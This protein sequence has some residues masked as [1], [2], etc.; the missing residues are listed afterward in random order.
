MALDLNDKDKEELK[1]MIR[2]AINESAPKIPAKTPAERRAE[3]MSIKNP[4]QRQK[5]ISENQ[6][7]FRG[8]IHNGL[9]N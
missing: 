8:Y 4:L 2:N 1:N 7:L 3:I 9:Y 5:A 6:D